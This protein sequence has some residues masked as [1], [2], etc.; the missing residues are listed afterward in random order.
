VYCNQPLCVEWCKR[1]CQGSTCMLLPT[2]IVKNAA[3]L[4]YYSTSQRPRHP[5]VVPFPSLPT[6][7]L[8][9]ESGLLSPTMLLH[10]S[11]HRLHMY[12]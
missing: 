4:H 7:L 2:A 9:A 3:L 12:K 6:R 11:F 5:R 1:G 8:L 10:G